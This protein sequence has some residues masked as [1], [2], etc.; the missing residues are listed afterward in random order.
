MGNIQP[1]DI[2]KKEQ[3]SHMNEY[4]YKLNSKL[5]KKIVNYEE[6]QI[7][8]QISQ[9]L[10]RLKQQGLSI[11]NELESQNKLID[12]LGDNIDKVNVRINKN[13]TQIK[14]VNNF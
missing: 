8:D 4:E 14:K 10:A 6:E 1:S 11:S 2:T 12:N 9:G 7:L 13:N 3:S 5:E